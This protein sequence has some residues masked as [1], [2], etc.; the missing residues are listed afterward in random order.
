MAKLAV[1]FFFFT[2]IVQSRRKY[3]AYILICLLSALLALPYP[4]LLSSQLSFTDTIRIK[5]FIELSEKADSV[6][7]V[8]HATSAIALADSLLHQLS[9]APE[10]RKKGILEFKESACRSLA[11]YYRTEGNIALE[12]KYFEQCLEL[13]KRVSSKRNIAS[14]YVNIGISYYKMGYVT[15]SLDYFAQSIKLLEEVGDTAYVATMLNN[16]GTIIRNQ[17]EPVEALSYFNRALNLSKLVNDKPGIALS[18]NNIGGIYYSQGRIEFAEECFKQSMKESEGLN[19][20]SLEAT[21]LNSLGHISKHKAELNKAMEYYLRGLQLS[22][23]SGDKPAMAKSYNHIANVYLLQK[24]YALA[25][26]SGNRSLS[27]SKQQKY[28]D[29]IRTAE[30][31]LAR[32]D[33]ARGNYSGAFYHYRQFIFYR[34]SVLNQE[35]RKASIKNQLKYEFDRKEADARTEQNR[36]DVIANQQLQR[37]KLV[38]NGFIGGFAVVLF[39]AGIFFKQR[40]NISNE[41]KRSEDLLLNIL[42]A[43]VA[44]ELKVKG[45]ANAKHFDDVTVFFSDF[46]GFTKVSEC[47]SPQELVDELHACFSA[48]DAV[49][50]KYTIEK[51]KTVGDAYMAVSGLPL[52]DKDH[53]ENMVKAATEMNRFIKNRR[54]ELGD[55][56]FEA[57]I[58]IHSGSVVAGIVGV[59]KFAYD[60]WGDTVNTA[61]RMEQNSEAGKINISETTYELVKDKFSCEYRGEIEAKN[62]GK[63]KMYFVV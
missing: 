17:G 2:S 16:L 60:I 49:M 37:Q 61:A 39:F 12:L 41:K 19:D 13:R 34:D 51:I 33:S 24:N 58:G 8:R 5:Q 43:E 9:S 28:I 54:Q 10:A 53:A 21:S 25:L 38:R 26:Q 4:H 46:V 62:K 23:K 45:T 7:K 52:P 29:N 32:V 22:E 31:T 44:E 55:K 47:L 27:L 59:K 50:E 40:N 6:Q 35:T 14:A 42:P 57:R 56:T 63:L 11:F 15:R 1:R 48:F 30:E 3:P 36:K 18:L 20:K